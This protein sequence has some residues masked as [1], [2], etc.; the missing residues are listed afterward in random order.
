MY[1]EELKNTAFVI[2]CQPEGAVRLSKRVGD[3]EGKNCQRNRESIWE[4]QTYF[5][6]EARDSDKKKIL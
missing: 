1:D 2:G 3:E 5:S 4:G 6:T